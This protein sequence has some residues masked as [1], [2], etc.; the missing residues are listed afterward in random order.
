MREKNFSN[1]KTV[2]FISKETRRNQKEMS[3]FLVNRKKN[4]R[5]NNNYNYKIVI[6]YCHNNNDNDN[7]DG[8]GAGNNNKM[9]SAGFA[10]TS[11]KQNSNAAKKLVKGNAIQTE[12]SST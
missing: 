8:N 2:L 1:Q 11:A 7:D 12:H 5:N 6:Q 4:Y 10:C 3:L 9:L